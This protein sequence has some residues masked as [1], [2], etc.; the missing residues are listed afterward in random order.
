MKLRLAQPINQEALD[1]A[2]GEFREQCRFLGL[3]DKLAGLMTLAFNE[4]GTN[5][6][7]HSQSHW[8]E[9]ALDLED[10]RAVL[11]FRDDGEAFDSVEAMDLFDAPVPEI[12]RHMGLY[13]LGRMPFEKCYRR[14]D[15]GINEFV[16]RQPGTAA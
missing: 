10:G 8:F 16:L 2:Q 3:D 15:G 1:Q 4:V 5:V 9:A 7:E 13:M 12:D 14:L 11:T 6:M